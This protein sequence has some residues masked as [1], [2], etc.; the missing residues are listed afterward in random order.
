MT[1]NVKVAMIF[2]VAIPV[3]GF[4]L[5]FIAK[6]A[7]KYFVQVFDEYDVLN[8]TVQENVNAA[9]VGQGPMYGRIMRSRNSTGFP[10]LSSGCLPRLRRL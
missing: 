4:A 3:L 7:H 1:I 6:T 5:I 2:L 9:R 8:N 10:A